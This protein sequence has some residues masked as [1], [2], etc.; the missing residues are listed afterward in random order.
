MLLRVPHRVL[1]IL[2]VLWLGGCTATMADRPMRMAGMPADGPMRIT[3]KP[4]DQ[5][6]RTPLKSYGRLIRDFD[7]SLTE[8]EKK[9]VITALQ[10]DRERS[11]EARL[12]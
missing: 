3:A 5:S 2:L 1:A 8:A 12:R 10:E 9:A 6:V 4:A 11:R 7:R